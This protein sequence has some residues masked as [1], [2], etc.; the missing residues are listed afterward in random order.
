MWY[1][2][3]RDTLSIMNFQRTVVASL[4]VWTLIPV[5]TF[6]RETRNP[7]IVTFDV[8]ELLFSLQIKE[9]S[10][11]LVGFTATPTGDHHG[12]LFDNGQ[13]TA[14]YRDGEK[15]YSGMSSKCSQQAYFFWMTDDGHL[16]YTPNC[17][18]LYLDDTLLVNNS[19]VLEMGVTNAA[20]EKGVFYYI[21]GSSI[22]GYKPSTKKRDVLYKHNVVRILYLRKNG[23]HIAYATE[24]SFEKYAIYRDGKKLADQKIDNPTNF[25]LTKEG[26]VYYFTY[27]DDKYS[28][29]KDK[30]KFFTG[31]GI[32]ASI[33]EDD[34]GVVWHA[35]YINNTDPNK[36]IISFYKAQNKKNLFPS[37]V[38][39]LEGAI[40]FKNSQPAVRVLKKG[41]KNDF[42]LFKN[43]KMIGKA[44]KFFPV[45][46]NGPFFASNGKVYMRNYDG[47]RWQAYED[48]QPILQNAFS[49]VWLVKKQADDSIAIYGY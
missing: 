49:Q 33:F 7:Q 36:I 46:Y 42:Y 8:N 21:N 19:T 6:A 12:F 26:D 20:Y 34:N 1:S 16:V 5:S 37:T 48:G 32:G 45:D 29:Y 13:S 14:I 23:E 22:E 17:T 38:G 25:L 40:I 10:A 44:F 15:V 2:Y 3:I 43:L 39:N 35:S 47:T 11:N 30:R 31:K 9:P 28:I 27:N 24:E 18:S 4:L 41:T